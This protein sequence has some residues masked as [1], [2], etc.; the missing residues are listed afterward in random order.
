MLCRDLER[1]RERHRQAGLDIPAW[2]VRFESVVFKAGFQAV[3]LYRFSHWLETARWNR[4]AWFVA[5][6]NLSLTGADIEFSARIGPGL[7]IAHPVGVVIGRG[8][9]IGSEATVFQG[10]TCGIRHW[11]AG[12]ASAYPWIGDRVVLFARCSVLGGIRVGHRAVIGAHALVVRDVPDDGIARGTAAIVSEGCAG[13]S[14]EGP[15]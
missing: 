8:T 3:L 4:L 13:E 10:V 2:R 6:V 9:V 11:T 12:A 14:L 15:R 5:R 1:Y 7:L